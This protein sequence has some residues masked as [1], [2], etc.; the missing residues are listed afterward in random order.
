MNLYVMT[1]YETYIPLAGQPGPT[2][3]GPHQVRIQH[4]GRSEGISLAVGIE[5]YRETGPESVARP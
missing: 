1:T 3:L 4:R 2:M 5:G